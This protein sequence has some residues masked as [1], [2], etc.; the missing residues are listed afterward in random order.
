MKIATGTKI[1]AA[2]TKGGLEDAIS[3]VFGRCQ[4]FTVM[5]VSGGEIK[6]VKIISNPY[7]AAMGGAGIQAAQL[8]INEGANVAI[9][10]SFGPNAYGLLAQAGVETVQAQGIV[11]DVIKKYLSGEIK[12]TT[13]A[14]SGR[15]MGRG[16]GRGCGWGM[17]FSHPPAPVAFTPEPSKVEVSKLREQVQML[18]K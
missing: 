15:A 16:Y 3:P 4:T 8:A 14:F 1:I 9:A 2:T 10:G 7:I 13:G 17:T 6:N 18:E 11:R 12:A 5:E